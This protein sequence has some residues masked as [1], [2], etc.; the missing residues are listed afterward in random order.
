MLLGMLYVIVK[1][2]MLKISNGYSKF[3]IKKIGSKWLVM[4]DFGYGG[5][6]IG[7]I[8]CNGFQE[9]YVVLVIVKNVCVIL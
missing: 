4:F 5:I 7:V 3:K 9:K 6:D 2:E 1:E 8:G